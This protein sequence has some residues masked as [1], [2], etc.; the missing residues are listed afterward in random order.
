MHSMLTEENLCHDDQRLL[1]RN[2]QKFDFI[3]IDKENI[4]FE[5]FTG[6]KNFDN[7]KTHACIIGIPFQFTRDR[8]KRAVYDYSQFFLSEIVITFTVLF[9]R[10]NNYVTVIYSFVLSLFVFCI[11]TSCIYFC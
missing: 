7:I 1:N 11:D 5:N 8:Y 10:S 3:S 6:L 9:C 4:I 2:C